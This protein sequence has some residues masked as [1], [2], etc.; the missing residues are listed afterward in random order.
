MMVSPSCRI[1][2]APL[3]GQTP[4]GAAGAGGVLGLMLTQESHPG[5]SAGLLGGVWKRSE[6]VNSGKR[7]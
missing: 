4:P 1:S 5:C 2:P 7:S 6:M 3:V